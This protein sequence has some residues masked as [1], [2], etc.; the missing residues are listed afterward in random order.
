LNSGA[1]SGLAR[2]CLGLTGSARIVFSAGETSL[3]YEWPTV[4]SFCAN[5]PAAVDPETLF[6][7]RAIE[8]EKSAAISAPAIV[9]RRGACFWEP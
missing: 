7:A 9:F 6:P 8:A 5:V 1:I 3:R 4:T 2:V